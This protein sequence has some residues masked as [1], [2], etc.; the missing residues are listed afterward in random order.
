MARMQAMLVMVIGPPVF[1]AWLL[2]WRCARYPPRTQAGRGR[3]VQRGRVMTDVTGRVMT[4]APVDE[5]LQ[6]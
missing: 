2:R 1:Q 6:A 5:V 4:A 3:R